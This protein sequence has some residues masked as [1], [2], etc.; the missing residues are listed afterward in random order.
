M[1]AQPIPRCLV[2]CGHVLHELGEIHVCGCLGDSLT[3]QGF[4]HEHAA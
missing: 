2:Y 3:Q 1:N 4:A